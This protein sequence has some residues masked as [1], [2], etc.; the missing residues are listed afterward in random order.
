LN[1][2]L[3]VVNAEE[4]VTRAILISFVTYL[5]IESFNNVGECP[6]ESKYVF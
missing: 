4:S 2:I 5:Q 3:K 1:G 6:N